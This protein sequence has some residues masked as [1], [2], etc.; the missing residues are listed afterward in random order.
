M[1]REQGEREVI[2]LIKALRAWRRDFPY[3]TRRAWQSDI[4]ARERREQRLVK[5]ID[6]LDRA[7]GVTD[8]ES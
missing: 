2:R 8:G 6:D 1:T 7:M 3:E 5:A 4:K